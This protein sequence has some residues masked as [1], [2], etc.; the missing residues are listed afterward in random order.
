MKMGLRMY[1]R[2]EKSY[3][4]SKIMKMYYLGEDRNKKI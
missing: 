3:V 4:D 2:S 1:R